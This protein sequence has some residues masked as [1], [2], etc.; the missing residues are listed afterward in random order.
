MANR[1]TSID[2]RLLA[3]AKKNFKEHGF[4][5]AQLSEI[6][7][8]AGV[9][10]GAVY[11]RYKG[12]EELFEAV[13]KDTVDSMNNILNESKQI[14]PRTLSDEDL[15]GVWINTEGN[16]MIWYSRLLEMKD[17]LELI[18]KCSE[19]T[20]Y[21]HFH[22]EWL[23]KMSDIDYDYLKELQERGLADKTVTRLELH[24]I[25]S[26]MWQ[27][28]SEPIIH[29]MTD[30]EVAHHCKVAG[31]LFDWASALGIKC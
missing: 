8:E 25:V 6:C 5:R 21:S 15:V 13:V 4:L 14:D 1:D 7:K 29:G 2:P 17:G 18:L 22:D 19:G 27:L 20:K 30:E 31:K 10:T 9:T 28:Y 23:Y 12:K 26:A 11:K 3:S 16:T 24:V